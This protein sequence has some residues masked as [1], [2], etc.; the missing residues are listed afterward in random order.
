MLV[1]PTPVI[2]TRR[3]WGF[4]NPPRSGDQQTGL[5]SR[6]QNISGLPQGLA[7]ALCGRLSLR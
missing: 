5:A 7:G 6:I 4:A 1:A 3:G 2:T